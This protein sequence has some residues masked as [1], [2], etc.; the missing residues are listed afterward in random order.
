MYIG[1]ELVPIP[2]L[3]EVAPESSGIP[4]VYVS[5]EPDLFV[6]AAA[7]ERIEGA[8][9]VLWAVDRM[10]PDGEFLSAE[11]WI[12]H[13]F[14]HL[15]RRLLLTKVE[16]VAADLVASLDLDLPTDDVSAYFSGPA[17]VIKATA[18]Y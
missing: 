18:L 2:V 1:G 7:Q 5:F 15:M 13:G 12:L 4:R 3:I 10:I 6:D 16:D 11:N 9:T 14:E 17:I 8:V